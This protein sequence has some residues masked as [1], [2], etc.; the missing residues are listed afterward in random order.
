[1]GLMTIGIGTQPSPGGDENG[2]D[3]RL[4]SYTVK[5][6]NQYMQRAV[7]GYADIEGLALATNSVTVNSQTTYLRGEY[8]CRN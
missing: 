6:L 8:F 5:T 3:L 7:P 1:M 2:A 4:V